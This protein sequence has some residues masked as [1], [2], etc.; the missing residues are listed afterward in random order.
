MLRAYLPLLS[1]PG[2]RRFMVGA[3]L[4][5]LAEAM[6]GI[7]VVVMVASRYGSFGTAGAVSAVGLLVLAGFAPVIGGLI[8]RRGQARVAVP[9]I[10]FSSVMGAGTILCSFLG[11]PVWT[12]FVFY[13]L[14]AFVPS[15]G[16]MSRARW[17]EIYRGDDEQLHVAMSAEQVLDELSFVVAPVL[18][19]VTSTLLFPEAGLLI[20]SVL[21]L[22]GTLLFCS[23]RESEPPIVPHAERPRG[24]ALTRPGLLAVAAVMTLTGVIFGSNEVVTVAV[25]D[26][27]GNEGLASVVLAL[28]ALGSAVSGVVFGTR[29]FRSGLVTRLVIGVA[30]MFVLEVPVL[31]LAD[32]LGLLAVAM[33]VAGVAT[34]PTLI[35]SMSLAQRL[36]PTAMLNEGMTVVLT[37]L[38]VGISVGSAGS[39]AAVERFGPQPAYAVSVAAG[40]GALLIALVGWRSLA[41]AERATAPAARSG[42]CSHGSCAGGRSERRGIR[43]RGFRGAD[44]PR[45]GAGHPRDDAGRGLSPR[46][47]PAGAGRA[48]RS[49]DRGARRE[50]ARARSAPSLSPGR[51][52]RRAPSGRGPRSPDRRPPATTT[53]GRPRRPTSRRRTRRP[54]RCRARHR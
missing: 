19:V 47:R 44:H 12:L 30:L 36:V 51:P 37:G 26:A 1:A 22:T 11:A 42:G 38:I 18:A 24:V 4:G 5:R 41:R 28:F 6:F 20:A 40:L 46:R 25:A 52:R 34:A 35:T 10:A 3:V 13:A 9:L 7:S 43:D 21:Y 54:R 48:A 53:C 2:A 32:H 49:R 31:L 23:A 8:D 45:D 33:L 39:G 15:L 17:N 29:T 50:R 14:S 16:T 27:A